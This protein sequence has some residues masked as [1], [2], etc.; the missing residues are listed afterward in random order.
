MIFPPFCVILF[1]NI[2]RTARSSECSAVLERS[3]A[4]TAKTIFFRR[5]LAAFIMALVSCILS[6]VAKELSFTPVPMSLG[7]LSVCLSAAVLGP[8]FGP[9]SVAVYL[10]IGFFGLPVFAGGASGFSVLA[11]ASGGYLIG[12]LPCAF[13]T[14]YIVNKDRFRFHM[15]PLAMIA[16]LL[17]CYAVGLVW[18]SIWHGDL[19][20]VATLRLGF[21]PFA[22]FE[23]IKILIATLIAYPIATRLKS[24][25]RT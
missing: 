15:Y 3:L 21:I 7:S 17:A 14:G 12:F 2:I 16:G 1:Q 19:T 22:P 5:L 11:G 25:L 8:L 6:P 4:L 10:L 24:F 20:L 23:L 18:L 13:I 9:I